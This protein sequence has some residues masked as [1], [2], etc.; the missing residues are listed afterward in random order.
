MKA[1]IELPETGGPSASGGGPE[2]GKAK[3][4]TAQSGV[5]TH[6]IVMIKAS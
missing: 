6:A 1:K 5:R 4:R 2:I 3:K